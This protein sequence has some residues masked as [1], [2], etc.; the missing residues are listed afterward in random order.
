MHSCGGMRPHA[1]L[2]SRAI[3]R[4]PDLREPRRYDFDIS[5]DPNPHLAFGGYGPHFCIG[6]HLARTQ[7]RAVFRELLPLL[8]KLQVAGDLVRMRNLH[9]GGYTALPVRR[10]E[11]AALAG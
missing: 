10:G 3:L 5:R 11:S 8:P 2:C 9:V 4:G 6:A 7:L 1:V